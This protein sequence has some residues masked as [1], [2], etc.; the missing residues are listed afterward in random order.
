MQFLKTA[1]I[2][3]VAATTALATP[4]DTGTDAIE[5][6]G[7]DARGVNTYN[8]KCSEL[9]R[10]TFAGNEYVCRNSYCSQQNV[11]EKARAVIAPNEKGKYVAKCPMNLLPYAWSWPP[12]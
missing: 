7:L 12:A 6:D 11:D 10:V 5:G 1:T 2:L 9:G 8:G 3:A 4:V